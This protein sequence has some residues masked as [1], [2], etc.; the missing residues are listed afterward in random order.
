MK[1]EEVKIKNEKSHETLKIYLHFL[2]SKHS[3]SQKS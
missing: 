3:K 2:K 1:K